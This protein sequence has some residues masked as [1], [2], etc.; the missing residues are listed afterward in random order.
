MTINTCIFINALVSGAP[1]LVDRVFAIHAGSREFDSLGRHMSKLFFRS[2]RPG[3]PHP[4]CSELEK[5]VSDWGSVIA[6]SLNVSDGI[7][8]INQAKLYMT[9]CTQNTTHTV[10]MFL[11]WFRTLGQWPH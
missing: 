1:G 8:L 6:A 2:T 7:R 4:V 5:V 11:I 3:H 9:L 10:V